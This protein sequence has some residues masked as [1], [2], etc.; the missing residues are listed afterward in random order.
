MNQDL[1]TIM[2]PP[3][4]H[5]HTTPRPVR[6]FTRQGFTLLEVLVALVIV[7]TTL[8]VCLAAVGVMTKISQDLRSVTLATWAVENRMVQVRLGA[9]KPGFGKRTFD[10]PQADLKLVCEEDVLS[11]PNRNFRKLE[12]TVH[13]ALT[14]GRRITRMVQLVPING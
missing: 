12:I 8:T 2:L 14:P 11:T 10:C 13:D 4:P 1:A 9:E 5:C 6:G 7:G 3:T